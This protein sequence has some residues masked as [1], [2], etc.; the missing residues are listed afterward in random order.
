MKV[1]LVEFNELTPALM[2]RF[3]AEGR[4][5]NF[6]RM[7]RES[8]VYTTHAEEREPDLEPWIQWVTV[9]SGLPYREHRVFHLGQGH[10]LTARR[11]WDVGA[12]PGPRQPVS[13]SIKAKTVA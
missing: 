8:L 4:L 6:A 10:D 3:I 12:A 13:G 9:H 7:R 11:V 2:D 1:L 5:P